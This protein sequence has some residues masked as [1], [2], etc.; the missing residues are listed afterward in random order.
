MRGLVDLARVSGKKKFLKPVEDYLAWC[1]K[2]RSVTGGLPEA[3]PYSE[4]DEGCGLADW[5]VVNLMM[6][7]ATGENRYFDSAEHTLVNHFFLNQFHT[8]GFGHLSFTQEIVGGKLWQ[9]W[10]GRFGSE[11]PGCCSLWGMWA[12]GQ[13]G[14]F[15]ALETDDT[16]FLNLYPSAEIRLPEKDARLEITGDFPRLN[17]IRLRVSAAKPRSFTL[18][19]RIPSWAEDLIVTSAGKPADKRKAGERI[20]L[21]REWEGETDL[22]I[23]FHSGFRLIPWPVEKPA[24][25]G[26]FDGP[27]CLGL[28]GESAD[29][30]LPWAVLIDGEGRP[31]LDDQG[32]PQAADPSG[33]IRRPLEPVSARWLIPDIK[34]PVKR[35]ILF[36][37]KR[38]K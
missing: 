11:N 25:V 17:K 1:R 8:G 20:L 15:I 18:A 31:V 2:S 28:S 37:T 27:L 38:V 19:L 36:Q 6:A 26:V 30:S 23:E 5:I 12:L 29:L 3:M 21:K 9:G 33:K 34:D 4:Q 14:R 35:R 13:A 16:V 32:R 22:D 10:K 24:G 7:Q